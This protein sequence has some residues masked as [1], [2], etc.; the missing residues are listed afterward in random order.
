VKYFLNSAFHINYYRP[1]DLDYM[2]HQSKY[3]P[4]T[5]NE[6]NFMDAVPE[7]TKRFSE[8]VSRIYAVVKWEDMSPEF[9]Q[10][11]AEF[12]DA[13]KGAV[14]GFPE[15]EDDFETVVSLSA[16]DREIWR[17]VHSWKRKLPSFS[18]DSKPGEYHGYLLK[19]KPSKPAHNVSEFF[20]RVTR[21]TRETSLVSVI[22]KR[23]QTKYLIWLHRNADKPDFMPYDLEL[24]K[25]VLLHMRQAIDFKQQIDYLKEHLRRKDYVA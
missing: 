5:D 13:D 16:D 7:H 22:N 24:L 15:D 18:E 2:Q 20:Q 17:N 23:Q 8:I 14:L 10:L 4:L 19:Q 11:A 1:P 12:F 3:W 9:L 6:Q 21:F 25:M